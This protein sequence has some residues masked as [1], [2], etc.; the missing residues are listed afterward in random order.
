MKGTVVVALAAAAVPL[1]FAAT[2]GAGPSTHHAVASTCGRDNPDLITPGKLTIGTDN[3]AF[4]PWFGGT[5][6][7]PWQVSDPRSGQGY[8]SA[9]AYAVAGRIGFRRADVEWVFV[10][11]GKSFAPGPKDFDVFINQ[12]SILPERAKN[13]SFSTSY[14][15]VNQA[16]VAIKGTPVAGVKTVGALRPFRFGAQIG[17]TSLSTIQNRVKPTRE[18]RVYRDQASAVTA[19]KNGQVDAIVV[20]LPTGFFVTAAQVDNS[21][22]VGQFPRQGKPEQFGIVMPKGSLLVSCVNRAI[23]GLRSD[24]TIRRFETKWLSRAGAPFLK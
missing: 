11:F 3:P 1:A 23:A 18:P 4:P 16:V 5:P 24:G 12:V 21:L 8:E 2:A 19:L 17:T 13:V 9:V 7:D 22:I 6:K 20:D 10:P 14:Y 15:N